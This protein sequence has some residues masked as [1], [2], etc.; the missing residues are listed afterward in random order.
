MDLRVDLWFPCSGFLGSR[1][2]GAGSR[3]QGAGSR[4]QGAGSREQGAGKQFCVL[5]SYGNCRIFRVNL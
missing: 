4:E 5:D 2:Q 3:E 1:E